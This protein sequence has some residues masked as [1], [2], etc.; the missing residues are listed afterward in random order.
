LEDTEDDS[1]VTILYELEEF[2]DQLLNSSTAK[3]KDDFT[4]KE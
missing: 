1:E 2:D 3:D 4:T